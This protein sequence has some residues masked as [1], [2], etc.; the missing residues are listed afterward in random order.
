MT[1]AARGVGAAIVRTLC[2]EG[3]AVV[4]VDVLEAELAATAQ[5]ELSRGHRVR[6]FPVDVS[7]EA[8]NNAAVELAGAEFGGL[9]IFV[10]NAAIQRL[11]T[12]TDTTERIWDEIHQVNLKGAYLGARAA[13]PALKRRG[14]GSII[15]TASVLGI[16]GDPL[17][18]AYGAAKGGLRALARSVAV[19]YGPDAI[20]CNTICPGD[21]KTRL[22]EEYIERSSNPQAEL[23]R[24]L[25]EYPLGRI[26]LPDDVASAALFLASDESKCITGTDL[27]VDAGLLAK[28]Y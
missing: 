19:A 9:D 11:A 10:A 27:V 2:R 16:V 15:L 4:A 6:A 23:S 7:T 5:D 28:C 17:L 26:A 22:F 3:C 20:R 14:G 1:G 24:I 18:A 25:A 12:L 8:G 21:I 13:I